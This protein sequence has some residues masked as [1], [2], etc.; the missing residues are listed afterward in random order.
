MPQSPLR[1]AFPSALLFLLLCIPP[2]LFPA[3]PSAAERPDDE[4]DRLVRIEQAVSGM[5]RAQ[6]PL[7]RK[8]AAGD[9]SERVRERSIGA[10]TLLGDPG[11]EALLRERLMRDPSGRVRRAAAEAA[12]ILR[13][14]SLRQNL[15]TLLAGDRDPLVRAECARAIGRIPG[16]NGDPLLAALV[17]DRAPEVR[18][19]SAEALASL[20]IQGSPDLL[21]GVA[22][23]DPSVF[24]RI[25]AIRALAEIDPSGSYD[26]FLAT[27]KDSS[28]LELRVEGY[29][30]LQLSGRGE[31]WTDAGL[32][33]VDERVR[34]LAFRS[35]LP[36]AFP[37]IKPDEKP[38]Y[39]TA[40]L[41]RLERFLQD[42]VRGIREL[43]REQMERL[44]YR[45]RPSG[46]G[47][48][49]ER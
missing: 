28:D 31:G 20:R 6:L 36:K 13:L 30:G 16:A 44:G 24:V 25:S 32:S 11:A 46:F 5:D 4:R 47:Y 27:W 3:S 12:G 45:V 23:Q 8:W 48:A 41:S 34:F 18:A 17:S 9:G 39:S 40:S 43:A 42:P 19:L 35:W 2:A 33:D 49:I 22:Q 14:S 1:R 37:P 15:A 29:R 38:A 10:M 26:L 21:R 7:L